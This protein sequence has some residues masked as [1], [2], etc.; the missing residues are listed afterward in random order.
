VEIFFGEIIMAK[1]IFILGGA[2]SGK[3]NYALSLAKKISRKVAYIATCTSPDQEMG[4]RIKLHQKSRPKNWKTVEASNDIDIV[5]NKLKNKYEVII[6]DCLALLVSNLLAEGL[7]DTK[8]LKNLKT[9]AQCA[10]EAKATVFVVS[11]E[12][13]SGIV[14]GNA[15]ARKFRDLLGL[16][17]QLMAKKADEVILMHSGIALKI[18]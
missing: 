9:L 16:S 3:S 13:G 18:K 8:I 4:E 7:K 15:L 5:L 10:S 14:P 12:V 2:R 6:I 1:F 17:N 11:N